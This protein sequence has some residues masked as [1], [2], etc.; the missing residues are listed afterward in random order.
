MDDFRLKVFT[1]A[2]ETLNFSHCAKQLGITQPAVSSHIKELENLYGQKLFE[3]KMT[4]LELT[5]FGSFLYEKA[6]GILSKYRQLDFEAFFM[7]NADNMDDYIIAASH[8]AARTVLPFVM[9]R[10]LQ[11]VGRSISIK[12]GSEEQVR[13]WVESALAPIGVL[14]YDIIHNEELRPVDEYMTMLVNDVIVEHFNR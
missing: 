13:E 3:R 5:G 1:T 8:H 12:V 11:L 10:Y 2:A 9:K 7:I 4:G 6:R 14:D